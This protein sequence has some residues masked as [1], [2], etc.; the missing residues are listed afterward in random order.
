MIISLNFL[1][2][3]CICVGNYLFM[4]D[5]KNIFYGRKVNL[6]GRKLSTLEKEFLGG[7]VFI[8]KLTSHTVANFYNIPYQNVGRYS[9]RLKK[10]IPLKINGR[11]SKLDA[12]STLV[13]TEALGG[14]KRIQMN[15]ED[16]DELLLKEFSKTQ[17]RSPGSGSNKVKAGAKVKPLNRRDVKRFEAK[18]KI[19][20]DNNPEE[21]TDAREKGCSSIRNCFATA[22]AYGDQSAHVLPVLTCNYDATQSTVGDVGQKKVT[23]KRIGA[24][25]GGKSKKVR[26]TSFKK[27]LVNYFVKS[28]PIFCADGVYG[29]IVHVH[30]DALMPKGTID[31]HECQGIG[32]SMRYDEKAYIVFCHD[33]SLNEAYEIWYQDTIVMP[34]VESLRKM[35]NLPASHHVAAV[36]AD[37][38]DRQIMVLADETRQRRLVAANIIVDKPSSGTTEVVQ[39]AD[40][41]PFI[42]KNNHLK[43]ITDA[44]VDTAS[45]RFKNVTAV[46][47]AHQTRMASLYGNK[48]Y[49]GMSSAHVRMG[50]YG[51]MRVSMAFSKA[52]SPSCATNSFAKVGHVPFN[53]NKMIDNLFVHIKT[54]DR[55]AFLSA[56]PDGIAYYHAHGDV[57]NAKMDEWGVPNN[58]EEIELANKENVTMCQRRS[59]RLTHETQWKILI[60]QRDSRASARIKKADK[61]QGAPK[62][63][64]PYKPK[65]PKK[66]AVQK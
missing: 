40:Q 13:I 29:D 63:Y 51:Q 55:A 50:C 38:E 15:S 59:T 26:K 53:P 12:Q 14:E 22:C 5:P 61:A 7:L 19:L 45:Q 34:F 44:D 48:N 30:A 17:E 43:S 46:F 31:V 47:A 23:G 6:K 36:N 62:I 37:G 58:D 41:D 8:H 42:T 64:K 25:K 20:T 49:S 32:V 3:T 33:R 18:N 24:I 28:V 16:Y 60:A 11:P 9:L 4:N 54:D 2:I 66:K 10:N 1:T 21:T 27:G 35:T 39:S 65:A 52:L 57:P 56:L